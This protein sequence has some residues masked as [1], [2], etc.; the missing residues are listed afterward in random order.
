MRTLLR[1]NYLQ[2]FIVSDKAAENATGGVAL[3]DVPALIQFAFNP[4]LFTRTKYLHKTTGYEPEGQKPNYVKISQG[5]TLIFDYQLASTIYVRVTDSAGITHSYA[6]GSGRTTWSP[7]D[8]GGST[9]VSVDSVSLNPGG[10]G[11]YGSDSSY[12]YVRTGYAYRDDRFCC[13]ADG[14]T[15]YRNDDVETITLDIYR[16]NGDYQRLRAESYRGVVRFDASPVVK[17]WFNTELQ[18]FP[19]GQAIVSDKALSVRFSVR[20]IGANLTFLA[21][22]GVAQV[23]ESSNRQED[24]GRVLTRFSRLDIYEGYPLDYSI[25]VGQQGIPSARGNLLPLAISRVSVDDSVL[26]V[27]LTEAA[28][29]T[30]VQDEKGNEIT[31]LPALDIPAFYHCRPASPFYVRWINQLG[32]LDYFMFSKKQTHKEQVKGVS[33][34]APYV[35]DTATARTNSRPYAMTTENTVTVGVEGLSENDFQSVKWLAF[36]R[37]IEHWDE[38]LG[39]WIALSVSKSEGAF[40]TNRAT[41]A[42]EITFSLPTINTQF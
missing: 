6:I 27:L 26:E 16:N 8:L 10:S 40:T 30:E 4:I 38:A 20:N 33:V 9:I 12:I 17:R 22:N 42:V 23:G 32:G 34:Y 5:T 1:E 18:E 11:D 41:H 37:K 36:A 24:E 7:S 3:W 31:L 35:E 29:E 14:Q 39:K 21:V 13:K 28:N 2:A 15:L 25:L 19:A